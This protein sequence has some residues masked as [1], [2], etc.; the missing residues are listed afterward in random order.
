MAIEVY[1]RGQRLGIMES[2]NTMKFKTDHKHW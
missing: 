1:I 2:T